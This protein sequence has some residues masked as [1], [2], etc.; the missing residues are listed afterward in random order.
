[1][2]TAME[3]AAMTGIVRDSAY[4]R[5]RAYKAGRITRDELLAPRGAYVG[6]RREATDWGDL[7]L[8][9]R[10]RLDDIRGSTALERQWNAAAGAR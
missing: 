4:Y 10:R 9:P 2:P 5:L 6:G 8:G 1:M 7:G 3:L